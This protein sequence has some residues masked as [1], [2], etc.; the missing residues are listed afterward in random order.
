MLLSRPLFPLGLADF[1]L[2]LLVLRALLY[3]LLLFP[4]LEILQ[5]ERIA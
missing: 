4:V 5:A 2:L 1:T 3:L